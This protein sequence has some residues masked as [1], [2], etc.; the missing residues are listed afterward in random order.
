MNI[1]K[2]FVIN[3]NRRKDR[4]KHFKSRYKFDIKLNR[5][6][7]VD[8]RDLNID[9]LFKNNTIGEYGYNSLKKYRNFHH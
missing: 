5:I 7:A 1:K 2:I 3:L 9:E 4:L 8:G 6:E